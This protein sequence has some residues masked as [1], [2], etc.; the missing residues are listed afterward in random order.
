MDGLTKPEDGKP[1][2][3]KS[4]QF[5]IWAYGVVAGG[6]VVIAGTTVVV[7]HIIAKKKRH[8]EAIENSKLSFDQMTPRDFILQRPHVIAAIN[9]KE[10]Q[11]K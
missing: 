11:G 9:Y 8:K 3:E 5:P 1:D 6:T 10:N 7:G 2:E 4:S